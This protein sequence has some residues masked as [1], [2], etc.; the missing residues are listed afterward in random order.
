MEIPLPAPIYSARLRA[1]GESTQHL[2]RG[3]HTGQFVRIRPGAYFPAAEW[4]SLDARSRH[5]V[6]MA[7]VAA[8]SR[9]PIVFCE[10]SAAAVHGIPVLGTWSTRPHIV[11]EVSRRRAALVGVVSHRTDLG[12]GDL[13]ELGEV[14]VTS[15]V[16]TVLDIATSRGLA[17]GV[18]AV[19][20]ILRDD[21]AAGEELRRRVAERRPFPGVRR[22]DAVLALATGLAESPLESLSLARIHELGFPRPEQQVPFVIDGQ[23][24][25]ADFFWREAGIVGEADGRGKYSSA[26]ALVDEKD[27][28]DAIRSVV[29]GF[30]RWGWADALDGQGLARRLTRAGLRARRGFASS[31][32]GEIRAIDANRAGAR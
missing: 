28:E 10:R 11:D 9:R 20:A 17:D 6:A 4:A 23:L 26:A 16:R 1:V 7:A 32:L 21:P 22:V 19:D 3:A 24:F 12:D 29:R 25:R 13:V 27:R 31:A 14:R 8:T 5:L 2:E 15:R 18:V 30:A